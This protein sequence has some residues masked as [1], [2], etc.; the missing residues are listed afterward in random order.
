[1]NATWYPAF[2]TE[3]AAIAPTTVFPDPTSPCSILFMG[4]GFSRSFRMLHADF[5]WP[6]V[7][8]K[9]SLPVNRD[10][11]SVFKEMGGAFTD[12][13]FLLSDK[14]KRDMN[15]SSSNAKRFCAFFTDCKESGKCACHNAVD[16]TGSFFV[17]NRSSGRE[18]WISTKLA[19]TI[20]MME[21]SHLEETPAVSAYVG[22]ILPT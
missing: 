17:F 16:S 5:F 9:G 1:M 18:S 6:A 7:R 19:S 12:A 14:T 4:R 8:V 10:I 15:K 21:R 2:T 22:T 20:L 3:S 13:I 11:S